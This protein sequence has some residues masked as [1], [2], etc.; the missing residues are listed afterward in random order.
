MKPPTLFFLHRNRSAR[1]S[2]LGGAQSTLGTPGPENLA[3][4]VER[5]SQ[6]SS[7]LL[8][9]SQSQSSLPTQ[10]NGGGVN[11]TLA[12][13]SVTTVALGS[14]LPDGAS[15]NLQF[16]VG[17]QQPGKFHFFLNVEALP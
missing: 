11:S 9:T 2:C 14:P 6:F 12:V 5:N 7:A 1:G 13:P 10:T 3:A 8:D 16:V 17:I 4:P 15:I